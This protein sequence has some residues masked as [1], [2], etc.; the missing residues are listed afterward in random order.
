[1]NRFESLPSVDIDNPLYC[2]AIPAASYIKSLQD[3]SR[4]TS[5]KVQLR[6][7][8]R[9]VASFARALQDALLADTGDFSDDDRYGKTIPQSHQSHV[10]GKH[11]SPIDSP[12][13]DEASPLLNSIPRWERENRQDMWDYGHFAFKK[14]KRDTFSDIYGSPQYAR[15]VFSAHD[16]SFDVSVK[17]EKLSF[18]DLPGSP[19]KT[20]FSEGFENTDVVSMLT[21]RVRD[22]EGTIANKI[23]DGK[24][25]DK[26]PERLFGP[27]IG[28]ESDRDIRAFIE[29]LDDVLPGIRLKDRLFELPIISH[30]SIIDFLGTNGPKISSTTIHTNIILQSSG[31]LS[32]RILATFR[33]SEVRWI[34]LTESLMDPGGLNLS[35]D[36]LPTFNLPNSF[37]FVS[38]LSLRDIPIDDFD[39][40]HIHHLPRLATLLLDNT[41][42]SNQAIF[43]L[44]PLKHTLTQLSIGS[45]PAID[46]D[47]IP[48]I[49]LL[50]KLTFLSI[51]DTG[52]SMP[53]LRRLAR[54]IRDEERT[55]DIEIPSFC[56]EYLK[57]LDHKYELHPHPPLIVLPEVCARLSAAALQRNLAAHK[58]KN[59]EILVTG[60]K[61]ELAERLRSILEMRR[62]D[63]LV[64]DMILGTKDSLDEEKEN[65]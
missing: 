53:G 22:L 42:I 11:P 17:R 62:M 8:K 41:S 61:A 5:S 23:F 58:T 57:E 56:M 25:K 21:L 10:L 45:N 27:P 64:R 15:S 43:L 30:Q 6:R 49:I 9:L 7:K 48:A 60:G 39:L 16:S 2:P 38:E 1:M 3:R 63:L 52:V 50:L 33:S 36:I 13:S 51:L 24:T 31:Y 44:V 34:T 18:L 47:A 4:P 54:T 46:D 28:T 26:S 65:R 19:V 12:S 32:S 55:L 14:R 35:G 29:V 37:L 59:S 20:V 40:R